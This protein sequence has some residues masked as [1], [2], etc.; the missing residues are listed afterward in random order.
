MTDA[1]RG[2]FQM[3]AVLFVNQLQGD[4]ERKRRERVNAR[5]VNTAM[6]VTALGAVVSDTLEDGRVVSGV[7][8]QYDFVAQ[9]FALDGARSLIT[10]PATRHIGGRLV[11]SIVWRYGQTTIPR[12]L[13][14]IVITE[15]GVADLRGRTDRDCIAAMS[16]LADSRFQGSI[17][18]EAKAAGKIEKRFEIPEPFRNNSTERIADALKPAKEQGFFP[19]FPFGSDFTAEEQRLIPALERIESIS[20]SKWSLGHAALAGLLDSE[21]NEGAR[22]ALARLSLDHPH[23]L[24]E[25]FSQGL[26]R[27]ALSRLF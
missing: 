2:R 10:L 13:R 5:F 25:R 14:D 27:H 23:S 8:G 4:E 22:S 1:E 6:M 18:R 16:A 20:N 15:Y 19:A 12:H 11:S 17:I 21:L 9:A 7:G 24:R 26:V 3:A